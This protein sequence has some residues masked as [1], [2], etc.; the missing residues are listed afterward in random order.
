MWNSCLMINSLGPLDIFIK[1]IM[2]SK[3]TLL[4]GFSI[5]KMSETN[6]KHKQISLKC[7]LF[8]VFF[9][10]THLVLVLL[11]FYYYCFLSYKH[12]QYICL[13]HIYIYIYT[14]ILYIY[15]LYIKLT[16]DFVIYLLW[17]LYGN[18]L[19]LSMLKWQLY[20]WNDKQVLAFAF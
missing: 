10:Q 8:V 11:N 3:S 1:Q 5:L 6:W 9:G 19:F 17:S 16:W 4:T 13:P 20:K 14:Y 2:S 7:C 15:N 12:M 18:S